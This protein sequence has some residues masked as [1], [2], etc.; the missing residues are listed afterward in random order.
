MPNLRENPAKTIS[1]KTPG[2][3]GA[4]QIHRDDPA[5]VAIMAFIVPAIA[6]L[7]CPHEDVPCP[8]LLCV[9]GAFCRMTATPSIG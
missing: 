7:L 5:D 3:P 6:A 4:R 1:W 9:S 2:E 8:I